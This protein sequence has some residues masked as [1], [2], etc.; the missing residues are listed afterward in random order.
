LAITIH[1]PEKLLGFIQ[2]LRRWRILKQ[3]S[4]KAIWLHIVFLNT[5][6][7]KA[8]F[9]LVKLKFFLDYE[10]HIKLG[11]TSNLHEEFV[12][13]PLPVPE[14]RDVFSLP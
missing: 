6:P 1:T 8:D 5:V 3:G 9:K 11:V 10:L 4:F 7:R 13:I 14:V 12:V 2:L